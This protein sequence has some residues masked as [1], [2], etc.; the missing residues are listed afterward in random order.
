MSENI[1]SHFRFGQSINGQTRLPVRG[2]FRHISLTLYT[3][4]TTDRVRSQNSRPL[5]WVRILPCLAQCAKSLCAFL[6]VSQRV[7]RQ[8]NG[9]V[10]QAHKTAD[11]AISRSDKL[12]F[13]WNQFHFFHFTKYGKCNSIGEP[14]RLFNQQSS[15]RMGRQ[16]DNFAAA[17]ERT[18]N[19]QKRS[20]A[21]IFRCRKGQSGGTAD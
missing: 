6:F 9:R 19:G 17:I 10:I 13:P 20:G 21:E 7:I 2:S 4:S 16:M 14:G 1:F 15:S 18:I 11:F 12:F 5:L 8:Q 3:C